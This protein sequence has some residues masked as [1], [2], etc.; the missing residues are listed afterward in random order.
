MQN[1]ILDNM[2]VHVENP[3]GLKSYENQYRSECSKQMCVYVLPM[4]Q[5]EIEII[6]YHAPQ[7]KN[8][9]YVA[10]T[11]TKDLKDMYIEKYKTLLKEIK[12]INKRRASLCLKTQRLNISNRSILS[13]LTYDRF[14]AIQVKFQQLGSFQQIYL[15]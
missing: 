3:L 6:N 9:K 13:K 1:S 2:K 10:I 4:K 5:L 15:S 8:R 11:L 14:S 12:D 7:Q